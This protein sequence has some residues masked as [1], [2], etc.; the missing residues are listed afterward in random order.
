MKLRELIE[1]KE[2]DFDSRQNLLGN[3]FQSVGYHSRI[4]TGTWVH[5]TRTNI[6]YAL[7]LLELGDE[8][9]RERAA[10]VIRNVL[11]FQV[12]D[13]YDPAYGIWPW[14]CEEPVPM[15]APPDW[16]W[17]DFIGAA[18]CHMLAEYRDRIDAELES[19]I[20]DALKRAAWSIF[21]RNMQPH[22]TNIALM[23]AAVAGCAGELLGIP[24]LSEYAARRLEA[25][26][27]YTREQGGLNEYNSPT[28]T[29]VALH[30]VER[31]LQLVKKNRRLI[32][33]AHT[34]HAYI[35]EEIGK[36]FHPA[37]GQLGGPQSRAYSEFLS[38]KTMAFLE[39]TAGVA[40]R[41]REEAESGL[42]LFTYDGI[43]HL[44]CPEN[45]RHYFT[46]FTEEEREIVQRFV[47]R[48]DAEKSFVGTTYMTPELTFG[49]INRECFWT[50]RR[51]LLAYWPSGKG[52]T[53]AMFR[54]RFCKD[55][56]DFASGGV[57]LAQEKTRVAFAFN[58]L[59][60]R[61]D[62]HIGLGRSA[63][64]G[65]SFSKLALR[66]ELAA[67]D[68]ELLS[69]GRTMKSGNYR[70]VIHGLPGMFAGNPVTWRSG[71]DADRV[72]VEAVLYDGPETRKQFD[73]S[74]TAMIGGGVEILAPAAAPSRQPELHEEGDIYR[75][76]WGG[77]SVTNCLHAFSYD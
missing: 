31:I 51:P 4:P 57:R 42:L 73:E 52:D 8:A 70:V 74:L 22:Y 9:Y 77:L 66:F 12:I 3:R 18:L 11:S 27:V 49:S 47:K 10:A 45:L 46:R 41:K 76:Q 62:W 35:W 64:G 1:A 21:R 19:E 2:A 39:E 63:D 7:A 32:I 23:G 54:M 24:L 6:Y 34:L 29:F 13:P 38:P 60:D 50:Q 71:R 26:Q 72:W 16:N 5:E 37:T 30:E 65:F 55:G 43:R 67:E 36:R 20:A 40:S 48:A 61:G 68:A 53:P 25:F 17:A 59:T 69:D 56:K 58:M 33:A 44:P 14:C 15:M 28:Y 75:V